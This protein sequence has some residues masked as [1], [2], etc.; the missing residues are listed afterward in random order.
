MLG[1]KKCVV[2]LLLLCY[3]VYPANKV[4]AYA[5]ERGAKKRY[6]EC[7]IT[8]DPSYQNKFSYRVD[9]NKSLHFYDENKKSVFSYYME[10]GASDR[11]TLVTK[12]ELQRIHSTIDLHK[13]EGNNVDECYRRCTTDL[14]SDRKDTAYIDLCHACIHNKSMNEPYI[15][16]EN[17]QRKF[18][19]K[20]MDLEHGIRRLLY[21][22]ND[23]TRLSFD[24][25]LHL[26]IVIN[27]DGDGDGDYDTSKTSI[28]VGFAFAKSFNYRGM[29]GNFFEVMGA[30]KYNHSTKKLEQFITASIGLKASEKSSFI[31]S[32]ENNYLY[33]HSFER[34]L[35]NTIYRKISEDSIKIKNIKKDA[36]LKDDLKNVISYNLLRPEKKLD[37]KIQARFCYKIDE[38]NEVAFDYFYRF[39]NYN[40]PHAFKLSVVINL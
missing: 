3:F 16:L 37:R 13:E 10:Y 18:T 34:Y 36:M 19:Y 22:K 35:L 4:S 25:M 30:K 24:L 15:V 11:L 1:I 33:T 23:N 27:G 21:K 5:W 7:S 29:Q 40:S 14:S 9:E 2:K 28:K 38:I 12:L 32:F 6:T 17:Y 8:I 39:G 26:P 20:T 31:F